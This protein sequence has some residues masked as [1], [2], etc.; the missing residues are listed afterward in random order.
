M[1]EYKQ[2]AA[3]CVRKAGGEGIVL[4]KN[5]GVL[6]FAKTGKL[7]IFGRTQIDYIKSGTGSGGMVNT[8]YS[9]SI[10]DGIKNRINLNDDLI[11]I[12]REWL[13]D[14]PFDKGEG[15]AQ[16]PWAQKEMPVSEDICKRAAE[17][18]DY[19]LVVIGRTAGED[20][21]N[22]NE[23]ESYL[24]SDTEEQLIRLVAK[25]F[26]KMCV[27]LNVGN[28]IDMKWVDKYN[29]PCVLYSWQ[30]GQEGGNA[31]A[32]V[33]L[34][35][36]SPSGRLTDTIAY[37]I[38]DYPSTK[39]HGNPEKNIYEEDIYVGYRYFET[40]APEKVMYP[41]GYGLSYT[42]FKYDYSGSVEDDKIIISATV[43]NIGQYASKTVVQVYFSAPQGSLGKPSRQ[44]IRYKKTKLLEPNESECLSFSFD[45]NEMASYDDINAFAY[46]LEQGPY[47][48]YA[49]ENV[50]DAQCILT[51]DLE[52]RI[53]EQLKQ[54]L[55]PVEKFK[56]IKPKQ[57][58][59]KMCYTFE[60]VPLIQYD[61][62]Q[63][64]KDHVKATPDF[65]GNK[66]IK[67][68]DV[69]SGKNS[70][71]EFVNQLTIDELTYIV[72]G[73]GMNSPKVTP[74]TG[75]A[76]GGVS[77]ELLSYGIPLVC[78]SDGPSGI[79]MDN[80]T[81][82]TLI[83]NGTCLASTWNDEL[84]QEL[85]NCIGY[86]L[87]DND[88]DVLLAP[89]INIHRNP[90]NGRNFEYFSEDPYLSGMAAVACLNGLHK[91]GVDGTIKHFACNSQEYNRK[92]VDSIVS[93]RAL[94][95]I[96]LK[97]FEIAVKKGNAAAV[98]TSYNKINGSHTAT[99]FDLCTSILRD[100][101]GYTG[102]V[103]TDWWTE[104]DSD[105]GADYTSLSNMIQAQNDI[106]M[107]TESSK[108]YEDDLKASLNNKSLD[109]YH[110][111]KCAKNLLKFMLTSKA[112]GRKPKRTE[113][114][115]RSEYSETLKENTISKE[116]SY[117]FSNVD[118]LEL[119]YMTSGS[120]IAQYI[121]NICEN[122]KIKNCA[123]VKGTGKTPNKAF[124]SIPK[125]CGKIT[126]EFSNA[127]QYINATGLKKVN[128]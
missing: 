90:L 97:P 9:V 32:D 54:A 56:R 5:E 66:G 59:N 26:K 125:E 33:V 11:N 104:L 41:F 95:E 127:F 71:D 10:L 1:M 77:D 100:E 35:D 118:I 24:L 114:L 119:E 68:S 81:E 111:R 108:E 57:G 84:I 61:L 82:A 30:G 74:G 16:E 116:K 36:V 96:Y 17:E 113:S 4:L 92:S 39:N 98:M 31:F 79:R 107:V 62:E 45:I 120:E 50:R 28:I 67:I 99:S 102:F 109:I 44:L 124:I 63:R 93:E 117:D 112:L 15:W 58:N 18:S 27:A 46:V 105:N 94:R 106:Y 110:L 83:P 73:E 70:L 55:A 126:F 14:N 49:G 53:T 3:D 22:K 47:S 19:A 37:D 123:L 20:K 89:G 12:Y 85:Y 65:T 75:G 51:L 23:P 86:E 72:K 21:D 7:S 103:M 29:V 40:F 69:A 87:V 43:K 13:K 115:N 42:D 2:K 6:P 52:K 64:I 34:G 48:I 122:G 80:G 128:K 60:N 38:N 8:E 25:Y 91:A 76:I 121:I 78:V 101:W 88:I